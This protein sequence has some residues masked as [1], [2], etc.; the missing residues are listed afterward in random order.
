MSE[1]SLNGS[2]SADALRGQILDLVRQY[3]ATAFPTRSFDAGRSAVPCAGR[4]FDEEDIVHLVDSSLDFWLTTGRFA[5][6]FEREFARTFGVRHALLVNSG[7]SANLVALSCLTS[8]KL[9]EKR[10]QAGDEVITVAAGFPTTVN[11]IVQ[12]NLVP[13]FVD[14][15]VPTYNIDV[16]QLEAAR[17]DRTRAIMIAHTLGNPFDLAAVSAFAKQH[18]LW[19]IEDCCDALGASFGGKPVGTFGDLATV[20]FYPAH[21]ITMGEGGCVLT[22]RPKLKTLAESFRDWGRDC[23]CAP[24]MDNTCG[25]RFDWQLGRLPEGYDHKYIYSHIG[26]N[27]KVTDMQAAVG[28]SQLAKLDGFVA[29]RRRNFARLDAGLA[30]LDAF[31]LRPRATPGSEPSWFGYPVAVRPDAPFTR[32]DA[33]SFLNDRKIGTRQIFAGNLLRQPAYEGIPHRRI[34]DLANSDFVMNQAFWVGVYPGLSDAM[35]DY[36]IESFHQLT[37]V[38]SARA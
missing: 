35:V 2:P 25:Q 17:S 18:D 34:G 6:Q 16:T 5:E 9:G 26:Y 15:D 4:V 11:P 37:R 36:M 21:H 29:A 38:P 24:G 19:L 31:F 12:N 20:S 8:P 13:V 22:D 23:W 30:D 10:L 33:V 3:H 7:S 32:R 14:V 28:V 27:L 1:T